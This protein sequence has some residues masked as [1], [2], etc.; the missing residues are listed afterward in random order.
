MSKPKLALTS[1]RIRNYKAI[2]DSGELKL[3]ALTVLIGNNGSGKSS[4]VEAL[5]ALRAFAMRAMPGLMEE[6]PGFSSFLH[7]P[8]LPNEQHGP[9]S[10]KLQ[11]YDDFGG[12]IPMGPIAL[13][14]VVGTT[15]KSPD[16]VQILNES[17]S[18]LHQ[19][20]RRDITGAWVQ[21]VSGINT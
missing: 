20:W 13:E 11:G 3:G 6:G 21:K 10:W 14:T 5:A 4:L 7:Q 8:N 19:Q 1:L 9:V 12:E 17:L 16:A 15:P 2:A 18:R